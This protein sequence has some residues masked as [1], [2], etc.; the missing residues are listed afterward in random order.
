MS[1][2]EISIISVKFFQSVDSVDYAPCVSNHRETALYYTEHLCQILSPSLTSAY[3]G[4]P[5]CG[6][7]HLQILELATVE[8]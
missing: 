2:C 8:N 3:P 1:H 6:G 7:Y 5:T 4:A